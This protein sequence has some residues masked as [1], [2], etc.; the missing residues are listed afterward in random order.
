M[1][2]KMISASYL[3]RPHKI[4]DRKGN[5]P[6]KKDTT[7][8]KNNIGHSINIFRDYSFSIFRKYRDE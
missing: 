4:L 7:S 5:H 2:V 3:R 1:H 6:I 8:L